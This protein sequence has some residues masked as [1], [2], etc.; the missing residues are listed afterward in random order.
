MHTL[1]PDDPTLLAL[2]RSPIAVSFHSIIGQKSDRAES[3][4][5]VRYASSHLDGA[6][7]ELIVRSGHN[8][9]NNPDAVGEVIRILGQELQRNPAPKRQRGTMLADY[10]EGRNRVFHNKSARRE[11]F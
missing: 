5:V 8:A 2:A 3:D 6:S 4:G 7:S 11:G 1:S 10:A 9:F